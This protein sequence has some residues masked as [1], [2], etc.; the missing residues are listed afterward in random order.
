MNVR[1]VFTVIVPILGISIK[2]GFRDYFLIASHKPIVL[3][4]VSLMRA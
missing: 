3:P 2:V 1:A 4:S